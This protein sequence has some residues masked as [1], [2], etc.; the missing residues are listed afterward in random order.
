MPTPQPISFSTLRATFGPSGTGPISLSQYYSNAPSALTAGVPGIPATGNAIS[1]SQFIGK[2]KPVATSGDVLIIYDADTAYTQSLVSYLST[3]HTVTLV[4]RTGWDGTNPSPAAFGA[5]I[6][7]NGA[8]Y[9]TRPPR[10][11]RSWRSSTLVANTSTGSW[12]V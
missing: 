11:L 9:L 4:A 1:M 7:L 12:T 6:M 2:S 5:V 10:S 8:T 3:A